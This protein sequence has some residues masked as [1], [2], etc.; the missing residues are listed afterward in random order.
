MRPAAPASGWRGGPRCLRRAAS[1]GVTGGRGGRAVAVPV[2]VAVAVAVP[3]Q[4]PSPVADAG[5]RRWRRRCGLR[6][7]RTAGGENVAHWKDCASTG[8][9]RVTAPAWEKSKVTG[10]LLPP[11][12]GVL[13]F[14]STTSGCGP[15]RLTG[16]ALAGSATDPPDSETL[17][18]V[19][20]RLDAHQRVGRCCRRCRTTRTGRPTIPGARSSRSA[21]RARRRW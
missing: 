6:P 1:G 8:T 2:A 20:G 14:S 15:V 18:A 11:R 4:W 17:G 9:C 21:R 19:P 7:T 5:A 13:R 3:R 10:M 12:S 16:A